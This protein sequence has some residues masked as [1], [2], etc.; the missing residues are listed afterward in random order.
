MITL[1]L[2]ATYLIAFTTFA[3]VWTAD[4]QWSEDYEEKYS[5][6]M[7]TSHVHADLFIDKE[8]PYYGLRA[9]CAD[10][11]YAL[12]AIFSFENSLPFAI[13][14]PSGGRTSKYLT[15]D[16]TAF[17][18]YRDPHKRVVA[19]LNNLGES[20][21]TENLS[22][23]DTYPVKLDTVNPGTLYTYKIKGRFRRVIR[24]AYTI[25][26]IQPT[27]SFDLIYSTQAIKKEN[28][29]MNYRKG[30]ELVNLPQ[31]VW[32]FRKFK[33]PTKL[34]VAN[35]SLPESFGYSLEQYSLAK[36]LGQNEFF[37]YVKNLLKTED[38]T[39]NRMIARVLENIC[40]EATARI[41]YVD[42]GVN[43]NNS[44]N[45]R[46][47]DYTDYDIY[48][49]PARDKALKSSYEAL[50]YNWSQV[51][52]SVSDNNLSIIVETIL[53]GNFQDNTLVLD[54]CPIA[55]QGLGTFD[56]ATIWKRIQVGSL[57]S[58]PNDTLSARW[59]EP[60]KRTNCKVWY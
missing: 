26:D 33:W 48:S 14:N 41:G 18:K 21:G 39:P 5:Q 7:T 55:V 16:S 35:S 29:P 15:N 28:L 50:A 51:S 3:S 25:K 12:R 37:S 31:T 34:H 56:L 27:G 30:K 60:G 10:A 19:F 24:H 1:K 57:S 17:D 36:E 40:Q 9:D 38:E 47:M 20:V 44:R 59:G 43:Y 22:R 6:W 52:E 46:C 2:F 49:T 32:G 58:H 53:G 4:N 13:S 8:S 23:M 54:Y 11:A 45:G 42:Q